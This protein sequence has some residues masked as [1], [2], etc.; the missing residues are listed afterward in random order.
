MKILNKYTKMLGQIMSWLILILSHAN[1]NLLKADVVSLQRGADSPIEVEWYSPMILLVLV[2][3]IISIFVLRKMRKREDAG[4]Q[5][6][7][8]MK[9]RG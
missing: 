5:S 3:G 8:D 7:K 4:R 1:L 9:R 6:A 2:M